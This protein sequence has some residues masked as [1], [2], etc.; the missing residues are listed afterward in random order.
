MESQ[1]GMSACARADE[2][3]AEGVG[4]EPWRAASSAR[5]VPGEEWQ[6]AAATIIPARV[7]CLRLN[8]IQV[9][10]KKTGYENQAPVW[11]NL[12][13]KNE[14]TGKRKREWKREPGLTFL[15]RAGIDR[16]VV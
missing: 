8:I 2:V 13:E 6:S 3:W 11:M 14:R 5:T 16:G 12:M 7:L 1:S 9:E 15:D 4:L 10:C